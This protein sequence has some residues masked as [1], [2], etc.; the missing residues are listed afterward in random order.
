LRQSQH[1]E[2]FCFGNE[3]PFHSE[4]LLGNGDTAVVA[5]IFLFAILFAKIAPHLAYPWLLQAR[6][7]LFCGFGLSCDAEVGS[8]F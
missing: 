2:G 8:Q 1:F 7:L 6:E 3:T 4:P 5:S